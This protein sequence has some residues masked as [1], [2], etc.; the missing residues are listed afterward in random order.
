VKDLDASFRLMDANPFATVISICNSMQP[1]ISHLPLTPRRNG[2]RIELIGHLARA[3][4]HSKVLGNQKVTAI[5]H[6]PHAYIT[7]KWYAEDDVPTWNYAAVHALGPVKLIEDYEGILQCLQDLS[8]HAERHWTSGWKFFVP[9]DLKEPVLTKSIVG[10]KIHVET[11]EHK[12]KMGQNRSK[13]DLGGVIR[14]L[15]KRDD[16][17]SRGVRQELLALFP[18]LAGK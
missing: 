11:I 5:F 9:D 18:E 3:N 2:D 15:E 14:G 13:E 16:D 4:P 1:Y 17:G 10:F 8:A 7:P 12:N 6:G